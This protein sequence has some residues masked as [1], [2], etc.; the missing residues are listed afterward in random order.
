M[1]AKVRSGVSSCT[2]PH[3]D[4][5]FRIFEQNN[6]AVQDKGMKGAIKQTDGTKNR[7]TKTVPKGRGTARGKFCEGWRHD[8]ILLLRCFLKLFS[9]QRE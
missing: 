8:A 4:I 5:H 6:R 7:T 9:S 2:I 3:S 1:T